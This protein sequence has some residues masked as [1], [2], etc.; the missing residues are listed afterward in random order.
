MREI[1]RLCFEQFTDQ[2]TFLLNPLAELIFV[3]ILHK[4]VYKLAFSVVGD[5]Y[6]SGIISGSLTGSFLHWFLRGVSFAIA[7]MIVNFSVVAY[8][9]VTEHWLMVI[10]AIGSVLLLAVIVAIMLH[11]KNVKVISTTEKS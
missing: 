9:F 6:H 1:F 3:W 8:R 2:L 10:A 11:Q 4:I 5:L 7:W